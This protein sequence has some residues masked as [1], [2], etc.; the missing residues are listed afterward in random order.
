MS[1]FD[2]L[3]LLVP[4]RAGERLPVRSCGGGASLWWCRDGFLVAAAA[5]LGRM[6]GTGALVEEASRM[7]K[8]GTAFVGELV[9]WCAG[10]G[11]AHGGAVRAR[12]LGQ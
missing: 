9:W 8:L 7:G 4:A 1:F 11:R 12:R 6:R 10:D 3:C 5:R 2:D